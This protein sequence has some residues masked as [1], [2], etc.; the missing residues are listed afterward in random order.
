MADYRHEI[1]QQQP[2]HYCIYSMISS[3]YPNSIP[4]QGT[5]LPLSS[6]PFQFNERGTTVYFGLLG[7]M[8][9]TQGHNTFICYN[10]DS[11]QCN[12]CIDLEFR[13]GSQHAE[14]TRLHEARYRV[15]HQQ[16]QGEEEQLLHR[17]MQQQQQ[18]QHLELE[19]PAR[20]A[21]EKETTVFKETHSCNICMESEPDI[22]LILFHCG[23]GHAFC[24]SC[25]QTLRSST[26]VNPTCPNCRQ[27]Q[28]Y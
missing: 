9:S 27:R 28:Q 4:P 24:N 21:V 19:I 3:E 11:C 26:N 12:G 18:Q 7:V 6:N 1:P 25:L 14:I 15:L 8:F 22:A 13:F 23:N 16:P 2:A 10:F 20:E 5:P 17:A